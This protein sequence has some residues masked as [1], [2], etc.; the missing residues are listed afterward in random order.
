[1]ERILGTRFMID[2]APYVNSFRVALSVLHHIAPDDGEP[3]RSGL[4]ALLR[5]SMTVV[6][7]SVLSSAMIDT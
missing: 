6:S 3:Y 7:R 1:M 5:L 2:G 4:D